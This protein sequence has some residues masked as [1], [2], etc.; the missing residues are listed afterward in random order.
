M[1]GVW[2]APY[3]AAV[4]EP[5]FMRRAR[6]DN[7]CGAAALESSSVTSAHGTRMFW[8]WIRFRFQVSGSMQTRLLIRALNTGTFFGCGSAALESY[9]VESTR[10]ARMFWQVDAGCRIRAEKGDRTLLC[11]APGT[12]RRLVGPFR[13]KGPVPFFLLVG[14]PAALGYSVQVS[15]ISGIYLPLLDTASLGF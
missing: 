10:R 11:E 14:G 15:G 2:L 13:Q 1:P 7:T 4:W 12:D 6:W 9:V 3:E 5:R 8:V